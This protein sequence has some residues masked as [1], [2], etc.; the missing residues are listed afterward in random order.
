[1]S[2]PR[3]PAAIR[4]A[5]LFKRR[6]TTHWS[7]KEERVMRRLKKDRAFELFIPDPSSDQLEGQWVEDLSDLALIEKYYEFERKKGDK[8]IHRRDLATFLNNYG[9]EV[10]RARLWAE[11]FPAL[12]R[13]VKRS[14]KPQPARW[15]EFLDSEYPGARQR[16]FR[17]A[18]ESIQA[19]Y[20]QWEKGQ[21]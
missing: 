10:D 3:T 1:M 7:P 18:P 4:I 21:K 8:G 20:R 5:Q 16:N 14:P 2:V 9:G 15:E 6:L 11:K 12:V 17:N 19:E 13:G